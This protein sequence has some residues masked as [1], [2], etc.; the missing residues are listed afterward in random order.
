MDETIDGGPIVGQ[1][2]SPSP[3]P[4]DL[5]AMQRMSF[6][7]K[8]YLFLMMAERLAPAVSNGPHVANPGGLRHLVSPGL[9]SAGLESAFLSYVNKE[10]IPWDM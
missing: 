9:S 3:T 4:V 6:A 1:I 8:L 10:G 5:N 2:V 7:Q